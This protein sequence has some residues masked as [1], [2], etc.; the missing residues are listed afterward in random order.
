VFCCSS[1]NNSSDKVLHLEEQDVTVEDFRAWFRA[2][3]TDN[4]IGVA[5]LCNELRGLSTDAQ[6]TQHGVSLTVPDGTDVVGA[7][8]AKRLGI[9]LSWHR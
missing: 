4:L 8:T 3:K 5:F 9:G 7:P 6:V 2:L 1:N